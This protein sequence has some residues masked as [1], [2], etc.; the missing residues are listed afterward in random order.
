MS[1]EGKLLLDLKLPFAFSQPKET[2][3]RLKS[4]LG[5]D[6]TESWEK[7]EETW[8]AFW[9]KG[10]RKEVLES[11]SKAYTGGM[12]SSYFCIRIAC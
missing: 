3:I 9:R 1:A 6:T 5:L 2:K 12:L 4:D 7:R 11:T 10:G 8:R